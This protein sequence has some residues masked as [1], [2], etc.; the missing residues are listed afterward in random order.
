VA[1]KRDKSFKTLIIY[2]VIFTLAIDVAMMIWA[3]RRD[4]RYEAERMAKI[5]QCQQG[6]YTYTID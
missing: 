2:L 6:C 1:R 5:E 3:I 4:E